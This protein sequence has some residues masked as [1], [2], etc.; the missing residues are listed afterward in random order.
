MAVPVLPSSTAYSMA[1]GGSIVHP[2]LNATLITPLSSMTL[3]SRPLVVRRQ[4]VVGHTVGEMY[5]V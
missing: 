2:G 5:T 1:A 3:A 4:V